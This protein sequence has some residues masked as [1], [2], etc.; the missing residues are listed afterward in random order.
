MLV[1]GAL[2]I[3]APRIARTESEYYCQNK[4][5]IVRSICH[6]AELGKQGQPEESMIGI[7]NKQKDPFWQHWIHRKTVII[8]EGVQLGLTCDRFVSTTAS[9]CMEAEDKD[10]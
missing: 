10:Q 6:E 2:L 1:S 8:Y 4:V 7:A 9:S 3:A 5:K